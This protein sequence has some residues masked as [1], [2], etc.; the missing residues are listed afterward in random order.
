M[1]HTPES[2]LNFHPLIVHFPIALIIV[3]TLC[4]AIGILGKRD[5]FQKVGYLLFS[6]GA[7]SGII[8]ALTG[9]NAAQIAQHITGITQDL[10]QHNTFG[11]S[12]AYLS[13]ALAIA[14]THLTLKKKF[15]GSLCYIYLLF[16]F[17]T[18]G[19]ISAAGYTGGHLVYRH[20]AGTEPVIKTLELPQ[21]APMKSPRVNTFKSSP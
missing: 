9:E 18:L 21:N 6:V 2:P 7:L 4:D 13:L 8:A 10:D 15:V 16:A 11:T 12:A 3:G 20:G 19:L 14:R 5:F 17:T 1:N